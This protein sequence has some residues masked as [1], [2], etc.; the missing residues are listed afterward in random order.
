[1]PA[2]DSITQVADD[3]FQVRLPLPFALNIVNCYLLRGHDGWT[4]LDTGLNTAPARDIWNA[5]FEALGITPRDITQIVLTHVH[6]DHFGMAGWFQAGADPGAVLP[7][8]MSPREAELTRLLWGGQGKQAHAFDQFLAACGMPAEMIDTVV[9]SL[10]ATIAMTRPHPAH[11]DI[12]NPGETV[13]LGARV[14]TI[15]HAPGHSDGQLI[16]Y[17][18]A[19]RLLLSGDHVL[20]KI[21]P[22]IGLWPDTEP[23][24]LGRYL[25]SLIALQTLDVRLALPGHKALIADWQGRLAELLQHHQDRLGHT[26]AA[27]DGGATVYTASLKVF[28]SFTFSSHE[29]RFAMVETLAHLEYLRL[30]GQVRQEIG[31]D[32]V[33]LFS[34]GA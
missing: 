2:L 34:P 29:W 17:D 3:I 28:N 33:W 21:T 14:F 11:I 22:N 8:R 1:M 16:F 19:D 6:P 20:M 27:I 12:L 31:A 23:D 7:V 25:D 9:T 26:L 30:R 10:D 32:G 4:L 13:T 24:P 18:P 5:V 15:I